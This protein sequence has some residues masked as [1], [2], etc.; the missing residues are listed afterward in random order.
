[1]VVRA[2]AK[3][4]MMVTGA[5]TAMEMAMAMRTVMAMGW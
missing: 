5:A 4:M 3:V 2:M 1:M